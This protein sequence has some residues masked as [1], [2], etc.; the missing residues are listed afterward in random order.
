[1]SLY[2]KLPALSDGKKDKVGCGDKCIGRKVAPIRRNTMYA[3]RFVSAVPGSPVA[4]SGKS[5]HSQ[6]EI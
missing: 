5:R 3:N 4:A 2:N 1:M 6:N